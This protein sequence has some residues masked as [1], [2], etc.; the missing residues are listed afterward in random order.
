M[1]IGGSTPA[2]WIC[3]GKPYTQ[4][5]LYRLRQ[6]WEKKQKANR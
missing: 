5:K 2:N 1:W 6:D 3:N 4:Q